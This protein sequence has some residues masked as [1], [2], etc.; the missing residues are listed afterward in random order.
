MLKLLTVATLALAALVAPLNLAYA[1]PAKK[2]PASKAVA[3]GWTIDAR[4]SRVAFSTKWAGNEVN[5][6]FRQWSGDINF[7]PYNLPITK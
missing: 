2:A 1:Q 4:Q 6:T 3:T 5:G 7:D